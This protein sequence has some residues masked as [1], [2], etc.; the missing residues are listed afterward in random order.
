MSCNGFFFIVVIGRI[1]LSNLSSFEKYTFVIISLS[2]LRNEHIDI[3]APLATFSASSANFCALSFSLYPSGMVKSIPCKFSFPLSNFTCPP[4]ELVLSLDEKSKLYPSA[5]T[6]PM[7]M[8]IASNTTQ[9][10]ISFSFFHFFKF[11][12][13]NNACYIII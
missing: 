13:N 4:S 3:F 10:L 8:Q 1:Y 7:V 9:P 6:A 5:L 12:M 2:P 11:N